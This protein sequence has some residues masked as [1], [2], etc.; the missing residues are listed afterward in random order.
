MTKP[1]SYAV[2]G[3]TKKQ[4]RKRIQEGRVNTP[5]EGTGRTIQE[6]VYDNLITPFNILIGVLLIAI[7]FVAPWQDS[8]FGLVMIANAAIGIYQ[9]IK[10]KRT[11]DRLNVLSAPKTTV[12]RG[13]RRQSI[14][15]EEIVQDDLVEFTP[16][17]QVVIDGQVI[18]SVG[19]ELDESLL[20]GEPDQVPKLD[21][22]QVLSGSFVVAG[23]GTVRATRIGAASYAARLAAEAKEFAL[24][25]SEL[26]T[27]I[28]LM[29][30]GIA[31]LIA[32]TLALLMWSQLRTA[33]IRGALRG[34]IAGIV[35]MVPQGLVLVTSVAF[36]VGVI[37]LGRRRVLVQE[38]MAVEGLARVDV[39]CVDKTGTLTTGHLSAVDLEMLVV[40]DVPAALGALGASDPNPN[41][42]LRAVKDAYPEPVGWRVLATVPFSSSRKWS[43]ATFEGHKTW[44]IGAPDVIASNR[45]DILERAE[46]LSRSGYRT[47][48]LSRSNVALTE[49]SLPADL[50][51]A[52]FVLLLDPP[53]Q[54]VKRILEYFNSQGVSLK[55]I[56]GDH[57]ETVAAIAS[58]VGVELSRPP[59]DA[60]HLPGDPEELAELMQNRSIFGRVSPQQKRDMVRALQSRGHVVAMTGDG[61]NDVLALKDADIGIAMGSGATATRAASQIVLLESDFATLP[62]VVAEGRRVIANVERVANLYIT[63]TV[64]ALALAVIVGVA[65]IAFPFLPRH[66][67]LVGTVTIGIP[68]FFL[69]LSPSARRARTGFLMR[70]LRFAVPAGALA[71]AA[72]FIGY[73]LVLE[74]PGATIIEAR[75]A[76]TYVLTLIGLFVLAVIS[77]PYNPARRTLLMAMAGLTAFSFISPGL[78]NF[79]ELSLPDFL[80]FMATI[81]IAAMTG[82]I[83][84][85]ALRAVEWTLLVP[86]LLRS[87]R[88][89]R[90][91]ARLRRMETDVESWVER[92]WRQIREL[93]QRN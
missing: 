92:T 1:E 76:A 54:D 16:G 51:P 38:L 55:V 89:E 47:V 27:G 57:P 35:A 65:N 6:I 91:E 62:H 59:V 9:E 61:V 25:R 22:D 10:A 26:R 69:A 5:P 15:T 46:Q 74:Q 31:W 18:S 43:G 20:T 34:S 8:L 64:Y 63:K 68:S 53:R 45:P 7:F 23:S 3:L 4:V 85:A 37:R 14:N 87:R 56:S 13:G 28:D 17:D 40:D 52:A 2:S 29:L 41:S 11:L 79:F 75:T 36:A 81:G 88:A 93:Y 33:D 24:V 58:Q 67:T 49:T 72:T 77:R 44:V 90:L 73:R 71:A 50:E 66:L 60:R 19:L 70:V 21:G 78:R 30:K 82:A 86:G 83:M 39:L 84:F 32:P 80:E 42:T 48:L 12:I